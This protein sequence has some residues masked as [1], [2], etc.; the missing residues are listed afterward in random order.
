VAGIGR[1][2]IGLIISFIGYKVLELIFDMIKYYVIGQHK[3]NAN[4]KNKKNKNGETIEVKFVDQSEESEEN[5]N[6]EKK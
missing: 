3:N 4:N 2:L 6:H 5:E 1:I